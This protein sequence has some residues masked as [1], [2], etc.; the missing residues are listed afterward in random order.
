M[1]TEQT[2]NEGKPVSIVGKIVVGRLQKLKAEIALVDR[3]FVKD[4]DMTV[5]EFVVSEGGEVKS[6]IRL[7]I[8]GDIEK[9][10]D[11]FADGV[12]S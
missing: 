4:L 9:R 6:F 7:E 12:M 8:G 1:L 2:L 11:N 3:P 10:G 5:E